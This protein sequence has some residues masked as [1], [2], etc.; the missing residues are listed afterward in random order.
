MNAFFDE[1]KKQ[2]YIIISNSNWTEGSTIQGVHARVISKWDE[3]E[4]RG[5]FE[6]PSTITPWIGRHEVLYMTNFW[7]KKCLFWTLFER[8]RLQRFSSVLKTVGNIAEEAIK[9]RVIDV[10]I[11]W[12]SNNRYPIINL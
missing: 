2:L 8:E 1:R 6:I 10:R 9:E 5:W 4:A 11:T 7:I 3:L 12:V